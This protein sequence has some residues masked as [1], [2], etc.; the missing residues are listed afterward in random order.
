MVK[1]HF[2]VLGDKTTCGGRVKDADARSRMND[3]AHACEGDP[4]SCGVDGKTYKIVGG[5]PYMRSNGRLRAGT[6]DSSSGCPCRA[7]LIASEFSA[8]YGSVLST[9]PHAARV[10]TQQPAPAA[11]GSPIAPRSSGFA[12]ATEAATPAFSELPGLVCENLWRSY[13]QRAEAIVAPR[14]R[15]IAD[16]KA[17]NSAINA[18][19]ANLWLGDQRF[20]WAGLAAFAS[21][22]VGCGLLHA[23]DSMEKIQ[24]EYAAKRRRENAFRKKLS[25]LFNWRNDH[26][27]Q[28]RAR[29]LEQAQ[30]EYEQARRNNPTPSFID[31][32]NDEEHLSFVQKQ[33]RHVYE[34]LAMGNTTLF[35]DVFPLHVFYKERGLKALEACLPSRKN[36]YGHAQFPVLWTVKQETLKF[37]VD[38]EQILQAFEAIEVDSIA[39]S[40]R[41]LAEHEQVN[42]LQPA[43]YNDMRL[44]ML[45]RGNHISYVTDFP[46]GAAQA[47]E[48]TLAS[49]CRRTD[50]GRTI[51][52]G[53]N[54]LADL[55]DIQQRMPFVLNAAARFDQHLHNSNRYLI[56]QAIRDIAAGRG[57]R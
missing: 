47:I 23:A 50:D 24:Q 14:G 35:L 1:G 8:S 42:I 17:R 7:R 40:V 12:P 27:Q 53:N 55:S 25:S 57:V 36:I 52:F 32:W 45:L 15:L 18:A 5:I 34:M 41:L 19:Y 37:G 38:H 22:Q 21:K 13:Q 10:A 3:R 26:E 49:Q 51:G 6:L 2:I 33:L 46:S 29:D 9:S 56:E 30:R 48:L 43:M 11:T 28:A 20:Q 44:V 4:V 54:P 16:P 31:Y 39:E